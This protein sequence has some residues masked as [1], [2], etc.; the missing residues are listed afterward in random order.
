MAWQGV[1]CRLGRMA[2]SLSSSE[3]LFCQ[4]RRAFHAKPVRTAGDAEEPP[5]ESLVYFQRCEVDQGRVRVDYRPRRVDYAAIYQ[6]NYAEL[7]NLIPWDGITLKL[8]PVVATGVHGW[9]GVASA[10]CGEWLEDVTANQRHKFVQASA[11]CLA[12]GC[13][14]IGSCGCCT[15]LRVKHMCSIFVC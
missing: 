2:G 8:K 1:T 7:V 14:C 5:L 9:A 12:S 3:V 11:R 15:G 6:G 10:V 4:R 13:L